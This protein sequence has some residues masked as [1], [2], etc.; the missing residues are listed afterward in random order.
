MS[1]RLTYLQNKGYV[2][3]DKSIRHTKVTVFCLPMLGLR[4]K[5]FNDF[6]LNVH[7]KHEGE[8]A[9]PFF[10]IITQNIAKI[11]IVMMED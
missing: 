6:L 7:I 2:R 9:Y 3:E 10:Y 11:N 4:D 5:D 1:L 8:D